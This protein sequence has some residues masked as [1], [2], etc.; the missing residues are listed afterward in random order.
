VDVGHTAPLTKDFINTLLD[1]ERPGQDVCRVLGAVHGH[2]LDGVLAR[3]REGGEGGARGPVGQEPAGRG[4]PACACCG[5]RVPASSDG[6]G[7]C[8]CCLL[9]RT[10]A[11][12][13]VGA[14]KQTKTKGGERPSWW[15]AAAKSGG[16]DAPDA[17]PAPKTSWYVIADA[18]AAW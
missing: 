12:S 7:V 8:W 11:V 2:E 17:A 15:F 5:P 18:S 14:K 13:G 9:R 4:R 16:M 3:C 10:H 1:G 6:L